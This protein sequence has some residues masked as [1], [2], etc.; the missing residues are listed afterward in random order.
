MSRAIP[1]E[2]CLEIHLTFLLFENNDEVMMHITLSIEVISIQYLI[3]N[4][5]SIALM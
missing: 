1:Q 2:F 4:T 5:I 3:N